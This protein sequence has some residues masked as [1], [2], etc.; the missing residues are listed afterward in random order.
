MSDTASVEVKNANK[1][2]LIAMDG[3]KH[4]LYA[5]ECKLILSIF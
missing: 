2:V 1:R 4:S 3:S 5:F